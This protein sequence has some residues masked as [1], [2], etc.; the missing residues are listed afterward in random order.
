MHLTAT[1]PDTPGTDRVTALYGTD[2]TDERIQIDAYGPEAA[3]EWEA[4]ESKR[5][6]SREAIMIQGQNGWIESSGPDGHTELVFQWYDGY[7]ML[8]APNRETALAAAEALQ[9]VNGL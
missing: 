2:N 6:P 7:L 8:N 9:Q 4:W 1:T 3:R 5:H